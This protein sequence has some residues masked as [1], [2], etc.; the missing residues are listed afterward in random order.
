MF[1]QILPYKIDAINPMPSMKLS[2]SLHVRNVSVFILLLK[3]I[4]SRT[5]MHYMRLLP[6]KQL[7][8]LSIC[9]QISLI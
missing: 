9:S 1:K 2:I 6:L 5:C 7:I 8:R 3:S 4:P